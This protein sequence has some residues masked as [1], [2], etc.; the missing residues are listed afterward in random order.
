MHAV[1][2]T[3]F[4]FRTNHAK[5]ASSK[6]YHVYMQSIGLTR[7]QPSLLAPTVPNLTTIENLHVKRQMSVHAESIPL[8]R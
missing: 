2:V 1:I 6:L 3:A 7:Q 8:P 4:V 5:Y